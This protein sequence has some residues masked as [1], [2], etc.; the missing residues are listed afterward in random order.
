MFIKDSRLNKKKKIYYIVFIHVTLIKK[1][2]YDV[3]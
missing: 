2:M 3:Y 1:I